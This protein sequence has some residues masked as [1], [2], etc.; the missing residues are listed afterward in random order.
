M[1]FAHLSRARIRAIIDAFTQANKTYDDDVRTLM[2]AGSG[3]TDNLRLY[4]T[5]AY[6]LAGDLDTLNSVEYIGEEPRMVPLKAWLENGKGLFGVLP[7]AKLFEECLGEMMAG[8]AT[9]ASAT[10]IVEGLQALSDLIRQNDFAYDAVVFHSRVLE[11]SIKEFEVIADYKFMHDT[12]HQ[13]QRGWPDVSAMIKELSEIPLVQAIRSAAFLHDM[14]VELRKTYEKEFVERAE[15]ASIDKLSSMQVLLDDAINQDDSSK[16]EPLFLDVRDEVGQFLPRLN[17]RLKK[18]M[19]GLH[20]RILIDSMTDLC[21]VLEQ[22]APQRATKQVEQYG[23]SIGEMNKLDEELSKLIIQHDQWQKNDDFLGYITDELNPDQAEE[24]SA[25]SEGEIL[26]KLNMVLK[27]VREK[28]NPLLAG[29][30]SR[31][32]NALTASSAKLEA[33]ILEKDTLK[34]ARYFQGFAS[35]V[36]EFFFDLDTGMKAK[37]EQL[38]QIGHKLEDVVAELITKSQEV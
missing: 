31:S 18:A 26:V 21:I 1:A 3:Y 20:L 8:P 22:V 24:R 7:E 16:F 34:A 30:N 11:E 36:R 37:C 15:G 17:N 38:R 14:I 29:Q 6:Q 25:V 33:L 27:F 28:V 5:P 9:R 23:A 19:G 35:Q 4:K 13:L 10:V 32:A 2:L 12:L